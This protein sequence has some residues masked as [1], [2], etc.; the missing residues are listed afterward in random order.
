M[1]KTFNSNKYVSLLGKEL[2]LAF[3]IAN[4][5]TTPVLVG[6]AKEK[7][8]IK[9]IEMLLP[10]GI[11]VG[12]GC[13]IDSYGK[14][15]RQCDIIIYE[16]SFCPVFCI[17]ESVETTY[18][19]CEGVIAAGEIKSSLNSNDLLN[20]FDK[21]ESVKILKRHLVL[22]HSNLRGKKSYPSYRYY[23]SKGSVIGTDEEKYD[24][25]NKPDDQIYFFALYGKEDLQLGTIKEKIEEHIKKY[26][27]CSPNLLLS[28]E[29]SLMFFVNEAEN[30]VA[31]SL[32][33]SDIFLLSA[34]R[35]TNFQF[36]IK[37]IH[38]AI[39]TGR[40]VP[41][42]AY[43]RYI[44]LEDQLDIVGAISFPTKELIQK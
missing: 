35:S 23:L 39:N 29:G 15:S 24:Q 32:I 22:E 3:E 1:E 33:D 27:D 30:R 38:Q 41:I 31:K 36:L 11:G 4:S 16:K 20:A 21:S 18:Y 40:T 37:K 19:P 14:T 28:L 8:V 42:D 2:V 6:T 9:K 44:S 43:T 5:V 34:H 25:S 12:S 10:E 7:A 17:N 26:K 13:V